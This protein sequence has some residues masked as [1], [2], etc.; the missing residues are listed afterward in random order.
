M[1]YLG[2]D[3]GTKRIG[4]AY[5]N[6]LGVAVPLSPAVQKKKEERMA[7]IAGIIEEKDISTLVI[8][9]PCHLN[10]D[11]GEKA[12]EVDVFAR[13]LGKRFNLPVCLMDESL[14]T[15]VALEGTK[16]LGLKDASRSGVLDSRA[17]AVI[18]QD[19]LDR[20]VLEES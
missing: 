18:L 5:G 17:A 20:Q 15:Y 11:L 3:Y 4:L 2:V 10:G 7:H 8:G 14:S 6:E 16:K 9:L 1:N 13:E 19:F 12:K